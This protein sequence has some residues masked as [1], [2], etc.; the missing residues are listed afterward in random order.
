MAVNRTKVLEA[1][2]KFLSKNQYDKAIAEYQKLV[3]EDPRDVRTLLKIGDLHT[4]RNKPKDAIDVYLQV[5]ELYAKQGFFLK[6]VAVY[7]QILKLEPAHLESSQRLAKMYEELGL[8]NDALT[9]Y[10]QVAD[11]YS[12]E[13]A[14]PKALETMERMVELDG[15]NVA[16]RIKYAEALSR[17]DRPR[18]AALAFAA[19]ARL[20]KEQG[21]MDDY[22]RV[23]ERQLYHDPENVQIA[24]ELSSLY[25]ERSDPKR[26]LA[27]LQICF[28][29]DPRDVATLEM[30]AEA[31]RQLGQVP[32]TVSVFKEIA[33][34]HGELG[35]HE[36][37]RRTLERALELD[38]SDA[39][40]KQAL[41]GMGSLGMPAAAAKPAKP[42]KPVAPVVEAEDD[43]EVELD[44][45]ASEESAQ[46]LDDFVE[47]ED[48][49]D[50]L[51]IDEES[52]AAVS[53]PGHESPEHLLERADE[54]EAAGKYD[55]AERTIQKILQQ[56]PDHEDAHERLKDLYLATDRRDDAVREL[57]WLSDV[58]TE[59]QPER[60][61]QHARTAYDLAPDSDTT[62][63]RLRAL[64]VNV[65]LESDGLGFSPPSEPATNADE[66][67]MFFDEPGTSDVTSS[68][69]SSDDL[70]DAAD[71]ELDA[72]LP[73]VSMSP[74]AAAEV[75][76]PAARMGSAPPSRFDGNAPAADVLEIEL[77]PEDFDRA[78]PVR[79]GPMDDGLW[80]LLD[81]P[82]TPDE[83]RPGPSQWPEP[84]T[85]ASANE[86]DPLDAPISPDEFDAPPPARERLSVRPR[87]DADDL[88]DR[89]LDNDDFGLSDSRFER[90]GTL[91]VDDSSAGLRTNPPPSSSEAVS[92]NSFEELGSSEITVPPPS[93]EVPAGPSREALL[94]DA[95]LDSG[96]IAA[97]PDAT[98]PGAP[99]PDLLWK[100][101]GELDTETD[102]HGGG[103]TRDE[104]PTAPPPP[105]DSE[106][107]FESLPPP[108]AVPTPI[109]AAAVAAPAPPAVPAPPPVAAVPAPVPPAP[110][111]APTA[112]A[113]FV[114]ARAPVSEPAFVAARPPS[115]APAP[116]SPFVA[117]RPPAPAP[118]AEA[119]AP[120]IEE[121]LDEADFFASQGMMDEALE[122][123][124]EAILIYPNSQALRA[125]LLEYEA[126]ADAQEIAE[127]Q[128]E[129]AEQADD[130][131]D[132]AEQLASELAE[133]EP[134]TS[135][136]EMV[137]VESVFAQFKKG[138][139]AQIAPDDSDTHFD[140]GIAYKEM[141]LIDDA[142]Q[143]F[144]LASKNPKRACTSLTMIGTCYLERGDAQQA[145]TYFERA[146]N[147]PTISP[148]EAM[149]LNYEIGNAQE[150]LG[151]L[152]AALL[153]FERVAGHDRTFRGVS[154]RMDALKKRGVSAAAAR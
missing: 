129:Q 143:E 36:A 154:A 116:A 153:S 49:D 109:P 144:D 102:D 132:I 15:G 2:Q 67:V 10:E 33:R 27:K 42:A 58:L 85:V 61:V 57:L 23:V 8:T 113:P 122:A 44:L 39:E 40:A 98:V 64:G 127:E 92:F 50:V 52:S 19:G 103:T 65:E 30:L 70:R 47:D 125:R 99:I 14:I 68:V 66:D 75:V 140:L 78:P 149:A 62:R 106:P 69:T 117:A 91:G 59:T 108:A 97:A 151:R 133:V 114:P 94:D 89:P 41:A 87:L 95:D 5:A 90:S 96:H 72:I 3:A 141:G 53:A 147:S 13:G 79:V 152:D 84:T 4:R 46:E 17:A 43:D 55:E 82:L 115:P 77:R 93:E 29:A 107:P 134:T 63:N 104:L 80:A 118:A 16:V 123:V 76:R 6:A 32:K 24:R 145:V 34:L 105:S 74:P 12:R 120:E 25:L 131:F 142:I 83:F 121:V 21:R 126:K 26:A 28:K 60:A 31:F 1:A 138:V 11:A 71:D 37:K 20:L 110:V 48:D 9:T 88:L 137:D 119:I 54:L 45:D 86:I 101:S 38:P 146:L 7:K 35:A 139:A 128:A 73:P 112:E 81:H 51:L 150:L 56:R 148:L 124:Q 136:D 111:A 130:S 18:D 135:V 100:S 22:L